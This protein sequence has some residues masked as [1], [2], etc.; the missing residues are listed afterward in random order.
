MHGMIEMCRAIDTEI[1]ELLEAFGRWIQFE[2]AANDCLDFNYEKL[3]AKYSDENWYTPGTDS[4]GMLPQTTNYN[5][6]FSD[7]FQVYM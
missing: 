3:M 2:Y 5:F 7:I 1:N 4:G 6:Q